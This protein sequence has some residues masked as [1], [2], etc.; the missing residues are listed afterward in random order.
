MYIT[1]F[2]YQ[3]PILTK[4]LRLRVVGLGLRV[5]PILREDWGFL[6]RPTGDFC[7]QERVRPRFEQKRVHP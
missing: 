5:R 1:S 6:M 3:C 4:L 2:S 7:E